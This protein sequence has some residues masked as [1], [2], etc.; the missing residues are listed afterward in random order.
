MIKNKATTIS[1]NYVGEC[2]TVTDERIARWSVVKYFIYSENIKT[3]RENTRK[4]N[5]DISQQIN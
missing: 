1:A 4:F 3:E 5:G 2:I